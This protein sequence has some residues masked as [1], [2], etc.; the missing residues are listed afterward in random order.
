MLYV[1]S[2]GSADLMVELS[3]KG[4]M[5][6]F[7]VSVAVSLAQDGRSR[8]AVSYCDAVEGLELFRFEKYGGCVL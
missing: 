1:S 3:G 8:C 4:G 6:I 5:M 2:G 7:D